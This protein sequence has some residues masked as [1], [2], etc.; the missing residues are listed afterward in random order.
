MSLLPQRL[1]LVNNDYLAT[2]NQEYQDCANRNGLLQ[3]VKGERK[4]VFERLKY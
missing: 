2:N 3:Y 1:C 4:N